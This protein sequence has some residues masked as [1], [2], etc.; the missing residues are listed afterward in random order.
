MIR[1]AKY[2]EKHAL[3]EFGIGHEDIRE[4]LCLS[5]ETGYLEVL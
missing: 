4:K 3:L 5:S 1:F 2:N